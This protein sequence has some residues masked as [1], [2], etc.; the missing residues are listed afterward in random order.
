MLN[1][2]L[3]REQIWT[4]IAELPQHLATMSGAILDLYGDANVSKIFFLS[5]I[6][7]PSHFLLF[8]WDYS[9][10]GWVC[11]SIC[12]CRLSV[13]IGVVWA[14][15]IWIWTGSW[16]SAHK[17]P[18]W[19]CPPTALVFC[20]LWFP[21]VSSTWKPWIF[22]TMLLKSCRLLKTPRMLSALGIFNHLF[23]YFLFSF[24]SNVTQH[25]T[26]NQQT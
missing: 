4:N 22:L 26:T 6:S 13:C 12:V 18:T 3:E 5:D 14:C 10:C 17:L 16:M 25:T 23:I 9:L 8:L 11:W 20:L 1:Q 7:T 24:H 2:S 15:H 21:G 19:T